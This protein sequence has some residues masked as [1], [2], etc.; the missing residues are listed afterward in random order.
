[1][2]KPTTSLL[3]LSIVVT[4]AAAVSSNASDAL[5]VVAH[6]AKNPEWNEKVVRLARQVEWPGPTGVAFLMNAAA[7]HELGTVAARLDQPGIDRIV[8]VP[9]FVSSHSEHYEEIRYYAGQRPDAPEHAHHSPL[10]TRARLVL[11]PG[12]DDHVLITQI[13]LEQLRRLSKDPA[14]ESVILVGHGPNSD[15][16][17]RLW[18]EALDRHASRIKKDFAVKR[19]LAVTLRDDAPKPVRDAASAQ[20][21]ETVGRAAADSRV[22]VLPVLISVGHIQRQI[23]ERLEG[24]DYEMNE[25]GL[26]DSPLA[27][28]WIRQQASQVQTA[29]K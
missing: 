5:L 4:F 25:T 12:M 9:L 1:M 24:L 26:A 2:R 15:E 10:R 28:D 11:A 20:L 8:V 6:G 29:Q 23:R 13:L 22:L 16:W 3:W 17:N 21:R 19:V 14:G 27:A 7:E 18:L